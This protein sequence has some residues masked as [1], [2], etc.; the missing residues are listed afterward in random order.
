MEYVVPGVALVIALIGGY[1]DLRTGK[2]YNVLTYPAMLL[3]TALHLVFQGGAGF[4]FSLQGI[5]VGLG[6]LLLP[7][8]LRVLGGGDVKLLAAMGAFFGPGDTFRIMVL[9]ALA[10]GILA[11]LMLL[12]RRQLVG[13]LLSL[14]IVPRAT[15]SAALEGKQDFPFAV[16]IPLG[17]VLLLVGRVFAGG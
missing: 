17:I 7:Y 5:G 10:G 15:L 8:L 13:T 6:L 2:V 4:L 1:T 11:G 16:T 12:K 9:G 3:G 14:V